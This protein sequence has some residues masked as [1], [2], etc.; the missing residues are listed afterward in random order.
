VFT[1][2]TVSVTL[3]TPV[4]VSNSLDYLLPILLLL[5][6]LLLLFLG[7]V[8]SL[9]AWDT[10]PKVGGVNWVYRWRYIKGKINNLCM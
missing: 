2:V 10:E 7:K 6:L 8:Y 9:C 3:V 4:I 5:L 1:F